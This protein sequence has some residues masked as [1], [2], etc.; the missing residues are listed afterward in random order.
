MSDAK[1]FV[2]GL[3]DESLGTLGF[4]RKG[5]LWTRTANDVYQSVEMQKSQF[6]EQFYINLGIW[7]TALGSPQSLRDRD[8][9]IR[10]R[11]DS[12]FD[13]VARERWVRGLDFEQDLALDSRKRELSAMIKEVVVQHLIAW[14]SLASLREAIESGDLS[15]AFVQAAA[16]TALRA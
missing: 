5:A 3:L 8:M 16:R 6:G 13:P 10:L 12:L 7:L 1:L 15:D 14:D 9:H 4:K 11:A 2:Q